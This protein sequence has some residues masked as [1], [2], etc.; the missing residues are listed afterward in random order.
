VSGLEKSI[1]FVK[2]IG[3]QRARLLEKLGIKK[4]EDLLY[5][6][7]RQYRDRSLIRKINQVEPGQEITVAGTVKARD[8]I[9][10]RSGRTIYKIAFADETGIAY[11]L[12]FDQPFVFKNFVPDQEVL[13]SG[14]INEKTWEQ[15]KRPEFIHPNFETDGEGGLHSGRIVPLYPLTEGVNQNQFRRWINTVLEDYLGALREFL[16]EELLRERN[17][18]SLQAAIGELHFPS[19]MELREKAHER[20]VFEE[21]FLF[22]IKL[23]RKQEQKGQE[24]GYCHQAAPHLTRKFLQSL[25]FRLTGSQEKVWKEIKEDME[26]SPPMSRLLQG[27]VGAGKTVIAL[28]SLLKTV[29]NG[30][31]GAFMAPTEILAEQHYIKMEPVFKDLGLETLLLTGSISAREKKENYR[32]IACG[33]ADIVVGTHA[34]IQEQVSFN[35]LGMVVIDEQHR[36]G[37]QQR[38]ALLDQGQTPDLLV[39]TA[40]P[41]PRS[42]ALTLYGDLEVSVIDEMPAGRKKII[43]RVRKSDARPNVYKF[44]REQVKKGQ[45]AFIVCPLIQESEKLQLVAAEDMFGY[46]NEE[47]FPDLNLMLIHG[48]VAPAERARAMDRFKKGEIDIMVSTTV[49]EV[50]VDIPGA[51]IM[52]IEDAHRFGLSQLHQLRGRVGRSDQQSYCILMS[53]SDDEQAQARL[54]ALTQF[55]DGFLLAEEDLR[56]RGAGDF[57]GTRQHGATPFR[58]AD[59]IQ[60]Q[61]LLR[62][63]REKAARYARL[64]S[65]SDRRFPGEIV[66]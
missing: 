59:L 65:E 44:I 6:I 27:D 36:F 9:R 51:T 47:I 20:L 58:F 8:K 53:D 34:L 60:H 39:M 41:I 12:W 31:Q 46:L 26:S 29:E 61:D 19:D 13:I 35:Q 38:E 62:L 15:F 18:P 30:W 40:T 11:A 63:A 54:K 52:L 37:V 45:Q 55:S 3:P 21:L 24:E 33:E 14:K 32:K 57:F 4:I 1:Q 64:Y 16:P 22:Q 17:W 56:L 5:H 7:P 28:L 66:R 50:G 49:I 48:Q 2:G 23:M 43:T 42:L 25:S 10:T